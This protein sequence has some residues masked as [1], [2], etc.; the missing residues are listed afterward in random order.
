MLKFIK[1]KYFFILM[2]V[3]FRSLSFAPL[4]GLCGAVGVLVFYTPLHS[5]PQLPEAT[6]VGVSPFMPW[7]GVTVSSKGRI[8]ASFPRQNLT[9]PTPSVAEILPGGELKA[10]PGGEWNSYSFANSG[11]SQFIGI[12]SVVSDANDQLWVVDPAGVAGK[13]IKGKAK[14]V[15]IDI[16]SNKVKRVY[17]FNTNVVPDGGFINDVRISNGFA[18]L[19]DSSLGALIVLNLNSGEARR[20]LSTDV[21]LRSNQALK[22]TVNGMPYLNVKGRL[23]N[24]NMSVNP[25]EVS[26]DGKYFYFQPSGGPRLF[27]LPTN[28]LTDFTISDSKLAAAIEDMGPGP[29]NAGMTMTKDGSIY[30]SDIEKGGINR[31]KPD[32][33]FELIAQ[34]PSSILVWPDA[35]RLGPDGFLYFPS[36]QINRFAGNSPTGKLQIQYPFHMFKVKLPVSS[37]TN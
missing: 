28:L 5:R 30:F 6:V 31:R 15:Q 36:S 29:F 22:L 37:F 19:P 34:G 33:S 20:V 12:N 23:P 21:R 25:V 8:F 2:T 11:D 10:Y 18:F 27:R 13:P 4:I 17:A 3:R 1:L 24:G 32:G 35:S 9:K 26:P 14:L 7:N 16:A